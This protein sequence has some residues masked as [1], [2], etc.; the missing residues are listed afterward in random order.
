M[1][2]PGRK[3]LRKP[4][5]G[6]RCFLNGLAAAALLLLLFLGRFELLDVF[7]A[8]LPEVVEAALAAE[9]DFAA[10]VREH[11]R[12]THAAEFFVVRNAGLERIW[13]RLLRFLVIG[14][15]TGE[16]SSEEKG[17][18]CGKRREFVCFCC[19]HCFGDSGSSRQ[20]GGDGEPAE[21][22]CHPNQNGFIAL[23]FS[24][25]MPEAGKTV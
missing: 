9:F 10:V 1:L 16:R 3:K 12:R 23:H 5:S 21:T 24:R 6:L 7:G 20:G 4:V 13:F 8:V 19:F 15:E 11:I 18:E 25:G 2:R 14:S 17:E 22:D